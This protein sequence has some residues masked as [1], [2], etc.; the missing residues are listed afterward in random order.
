MN[1]TNYNQI[2]GKNILKLLDFYNFQHT[3]ECL[4]K[5]NLIL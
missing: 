5:L 3:D 4:K 2:T 1:Q